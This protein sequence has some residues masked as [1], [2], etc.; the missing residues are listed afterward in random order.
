MYTRYFRLREPPFLIPP[1]PWNLFRSAGFQSV[2]E[3]LLDSGDERHGIVVLTGQ[4][5]IGKTTLCRSLVT[6]LPED[7]NVA[8]ISNPHL[9]KLDFLLEICD[10]L[11]ID[12]P[13]RAG[14]YQTLIDSI[15]YYLDDACTQGRRT[16]LIIDD[17]QHLSQEV[18]EQ[19]VLLAQLQETQNYT[20]QI[21]LAGESNPIRQLQEKQLHEPL[22]KSVFQYHLKPFSPDETKDYISHRISIGGGDYAELFTQ[23][24]ICEIHQYSEGIPR[25]INLICD[26]A[27]VETYSEHHCK[28]DTWTVRKVSPKA[29]EALSA[30][31]PLR[32]AVWIPTPKPSAF[33]PREAPKQQ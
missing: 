14:S 13:S 25:R 1:E 6:H 27:L 18:L 15:R 33:I 2:V 23:D 32:P 7:V 11:R 21:V 29:L 20:I 19:F 31:T 17:A 28:V 3:V 8:F 4:L 26:Q 30:Q 24:A 12:L 5:G 9:N 16:A 10:K 22:Q